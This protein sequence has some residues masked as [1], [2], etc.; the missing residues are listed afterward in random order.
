MMRIG[1]KFLEKCERRFFEKFKKRHKFLILLCFCMEDR[2][3]KS[4]ML[5]LLKEG[6]VLQYLPD[7]GGNYEKSKL[8]KIYDILKTPIRKLR[9]Y[10]R[11]IKLK[12]K[13]KKLCPNGFTIK[14]EPPYYGV[15]DKRDGL[16]VSHNPTC[17]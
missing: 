10:I 1:L 2:V 12:Y 8:D 15:Y 11:A 6:G 5:E 14:K 7:I 9:I 16:L 3:F 13:L 4:R 17:L